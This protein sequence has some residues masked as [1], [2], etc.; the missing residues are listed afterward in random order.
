M[1]RLYTLRRNERILTDDVF[2]I[3]ESDEEGSITYINP[4]YCQLSDYRADEAVGMSH[5]ALCYPGMPSTAFYGLIN[6]IKRGDVWT[7]LVRNSTK[8]GRHHF[9]IYATA[10]MV[11]R[12]GAVRYVTCGIKPKEKNPVIP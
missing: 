2:L 8:T 5:Y 11:I 9:W 10:Y 1:P 6:T 12:N 4:D 7:G 3:A